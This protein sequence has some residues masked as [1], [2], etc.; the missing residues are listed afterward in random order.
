MKVLVLLTLALLAFAGN[1]VLNRLALKGG[2]IDA[3]SFTI[4]R[5][6]SGALALLLILGLQSQPVRLTKQVLL[7]DFKGAIA[8]FLYAICFSV[9]YLSLDTG[10]GALVLFGVVQILLLVLNFFHGN[11][12]N[13]VEWLGV[14]LAVSG[15]TALLLPDASAPDV[16]GFIL[17]CFAGAAWGFYTFWGRGSR[18][19]LLDTTT[20]FVKTLPLCLLLGIGWLIATDNDSPS[21]QGIGLAVISGAITS[22]IGYAIWYSVLPKL[23]ILQSALSQ[24]LVPV[25]AA[26]AGIAFLGE[27]VTAIFVFA[28]L[29]ILGGILLIQVSKRHQ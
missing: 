26:A 17:M 3:E 7:T 4:I 18:Q 12:L 21:L 14:C 20:N 8:L 19:A 13:K 16:W 9:A 1:S 2:H 11:R 25:I 6:V 23:S 27:P 15:L 10:T 24:L 22:G 29:L 5:L 28:S